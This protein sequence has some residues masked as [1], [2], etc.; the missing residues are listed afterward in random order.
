MKTTS[1]KG[2]TLI[3]L[4]VVIA[5]IGILG[6][7]LLPVFATARDAARRSTCISNLK[8]LGL[9]FQQYSQEYDERMPNAAHGGDLG[10]AQSGVWMYYSAYPAYAGGAS[11]NFDAT[12]SSIYPYANSK[13]IFVCPTDGVGQKTGDSYAYNSCLTQ[14][15]DALSVWPGKSMSVVDNPSGT[16]LLAEEE[17]DGQSTNDGLFNMSGNAGG[18]QGYDS[19]SYADWHVGGSCVLFVDGHAKFNRYSKLVAAHLPTGNSAVWGGVDIC[20]Q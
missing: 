20:S 4:L 6:A 19:Q 11:G 8:Q 5:I 3:E 14:T 16:L 17:S 10:I 15:D 12:R 9:A 2:F 1:K 18:T 7:L 13:A